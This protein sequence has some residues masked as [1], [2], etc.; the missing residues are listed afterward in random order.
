MTDHTIPD[1]LSVPA[2]LRTAMKG[3]PCQTPQLMTTPQPQQQHSYG[4]SAWQERNRPE[5][6]EQSELAAAVARYRDEKRLAALEQWRNENPELAAADRK[7]KRDAQRRVSKLGI[8]PAMRR[9][10]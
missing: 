6:L 8:P 5:A 4:P 1:D 2:F 9:S 7:A 3:T 10:R